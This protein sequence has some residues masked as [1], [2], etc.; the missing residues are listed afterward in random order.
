MAILDEN[1][2]ENTTATPAGV[3]DIEIEGIKKTPFRI[4]GDNNSILEL[5]L[6]DM[7]LSERLEKGYLTIQKE[8]TRISNL[9]DDTD[10]TEELRQADK[11]MREQLDYIF[12]SNVSEVCGKGGSMYDPKDG[13]Y[14]FEHIITALLK[15]YNNN[16]TEEF[17]KMKKRIEQHTKGYAGTKATK[18]HK[19][20]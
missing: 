3:I 6:S 9:P 18:S 8:L 12:D 17:R 2:T 19:K 5:N 15:L 7:N 20:G 13:S 14:R 10:A 11:V 1:K 4:N 16:M